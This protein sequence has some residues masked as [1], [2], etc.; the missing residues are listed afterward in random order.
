MVPKD[1]GSRSAIQF[2]GIS[3]PAKAHAPNCSAAQTARAS[4]EIFALRR[5]STG[6]EEWI[7]TSSTSRGILIVGQRVA[8]SSEQ[9]KHTI[10]RI[11]YIA[12]TM[13]GGVQVPSPGGSTEGAS[14]FGQ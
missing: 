12:L 7:N 1:N 8:S 14:V 13:P 6:N 3:N 11:H 9:S 5:M 10:S 4:R 2:T